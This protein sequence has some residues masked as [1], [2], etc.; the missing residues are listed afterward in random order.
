MIAPF[1]LYIFNEMSEGLNI[2]LPFNFFTL[3]VVG[4]L[5]LPGFILLITIYFMVF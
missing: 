2:F 5:Q 1:I 4:F 3:F